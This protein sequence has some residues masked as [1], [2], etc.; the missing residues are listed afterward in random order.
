MTELNQK[1]KKYMENGTIIKG[2]IKLTQYSEEFQSD[3]VL[4]ALEDANVIILKK[5]FD[6]KERP[7]SLVKYVGSTIKFVITE[8]REDGTIIGSRKLVKEFERD[9]LIKRLEAG[10]E[11]DAKIVHLLPFGA[12][13]NIHGTI[14]ILKNID[15]A[16]DHT[17]VKDKYKIGDVIKV[18]LNKITS[19]KKIHVEAVEKYCNPTKVDFSTFEKGQVVSGTIKTIKPFACFV[20]VAPNLDVLVPVPDEFEVI[21]G[22]KVLVKIKTVDPE[23]ERLR[24]KILK[25]VDENE[26]NFED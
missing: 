25:T 2:Q 22:T 14:V 8:V 5:D 10:E 24:G 16:L 1:F 15:F 6:I 26:F 23:N 9:E 3:I 18:K 12:Y 21:E 4:I 17:T 13:L 7:D 20:C 11:F 19:S